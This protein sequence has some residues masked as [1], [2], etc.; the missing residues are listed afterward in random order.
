MRAPST[1]STTRAANTACGISGSNRSGGGTLQSLASATSVRHGAVFAQ[2]GR[3]V[4]TRSVVSCPA[5]GSHFGTRP[6]TLPPPRAPL[7]PTRRPPARS[8]APPNRAQPVR[9]KILDGA[10]EHADARCALLEHERRS[11]ASPEARCV[12]QLSGCTRCARVRTAAQA[13]TSNSVRS[14]TRVHFCGRA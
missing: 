13:R 3:A 6:P 5:V 8:P 7:P 12:E 2:P 10:S 1:H 4:L 11:A 14:W 9:G